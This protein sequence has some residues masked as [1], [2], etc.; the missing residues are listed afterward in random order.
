[1]VKIEEGSKKKINSVE[2]KVFLVSLL[3]I[4]LCYSQVRIDAGVQ[5]QPNSSE[6]YYVVNNTFYVDDMY[7]YEENVTLEGL[8]PYNTTIAVLDDAGDE[9][10]YLSD[11]KTDTS[12]PQTSTVKNIYFRVSQ[13]VVA[14]THRYGAGIV[15]EKAYSSFRLASIVPFVIAG[16]ALLTIII[17]AVMLK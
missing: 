17:G 2:I 3:L 7:V 14:Y 15:S 8:D 13:A 10:S 11:L 12:I 4:P 9:S 16:M 1:M 6:S 5:I